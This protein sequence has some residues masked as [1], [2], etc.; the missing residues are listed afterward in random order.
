METNV[1]KIVKRAIIEK[2]LLSDNAKEQLNREKRVVFEIIPEL[3]KEDGFDHKHPHHCYDVWKHTLVAIDKSDKDLTIRLALLLHDVGKPY[4][5]Q[6]GKVRHFHG[7]PEVSSQMSE[8]ILTRL[9]YTEKEINEICY[10]IKNHDNIIDVNNLEKDKMELAKKLL[11]IQYC[12]AYAH[13]PDHIEK[14]IKKLN[15]IKE[16]LYKKTKELYNMVENER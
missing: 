8:N 12:D 9:S 6:E 3:E 4:S 11:Q 15:E 16:Q 10:L 14:R 7:H 1:E 13:H 5:Y 2:M